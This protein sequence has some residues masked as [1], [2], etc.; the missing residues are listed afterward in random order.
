MSFE[1]KLDILFERA[2]DTIWYD[3][4][5]ETLRDAIMRIYDE[6]KDRNEPPK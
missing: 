1:T 4:G 2:P 5:G 6:E 3:E